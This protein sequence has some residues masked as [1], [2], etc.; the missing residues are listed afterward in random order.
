MAIHKQPTEHKWALLDPRPHKLTAELCSLIRNEVRLEPG[1]TFMISGGFDF[2]RQVFAADVTVSEHHLSEV[3]PEASP[4]EAPAA[5][6]DLEV[7][8][9]GVVDAIPEDD[10]GGVS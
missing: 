2:Q 7:L 8:D 9:G 4:Q 5:K 6:P 3:V 1:F 10:Q